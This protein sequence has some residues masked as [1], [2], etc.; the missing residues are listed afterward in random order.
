MIVAVDLP[1][2]VALLTDDAR[3]VVTCSIPG[4]GPGQLKALY[5]KLSQMVSHGAV[6]FMAY[7][8]PMRTGSKRGLGPIVPEN[9]HAEAICLLVCEQNRLPFMS[10]RPR[11]AKNAATGNP[12]AKK[13]Q[14]K[15]AVEERLGRKLK[16]Q[17]E[18]DAVA[19]GLE[20]LNR[21]DKA[22]RRGC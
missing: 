9:F 6:D 12:G 11:S 8:D 13:P 10:I 21:L 5:D 19:V 4:K 22:I 18:A 1:Q 20:A 15:R 3:E 17:H 16:T 7:E 2:G 14:V